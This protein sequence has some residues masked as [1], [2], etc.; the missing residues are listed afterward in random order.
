MALINNK[1]NLTENIEELP[2]NIRNYIHNLMKDFW[3]RE[4]NKYFDETGKKIL[5]IQED[6][7]LSMFFREFLWDVAGKIRKESIDEDEK[8]FYMD[9]F[10]SDFGQK[11]IRTFFREQFVKE[12]TRSLPSDVI[13]EKQASYLK[14]LIRGTRDKCIVRVDMEYLRKQEASKLI[15]FLKSLK[16][17]NIKSID[18]MIK[19]IVELKGA[20]NS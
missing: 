16:E 5:E 15:D 18:P 12:H 13:T 14:S 4:K 10:F 19:H 20:D 7:L 9:W 6:D 2:D 1:E 8:D 17:G 11:Y 3:E